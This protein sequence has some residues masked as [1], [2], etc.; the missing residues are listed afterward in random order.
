MLLCIIVPIIVVGVVGFFSISGFANTT[1]EQYA[2]SVGSAQGNAINQI[3]GQ[4]ERDIY[5]LACDG[6]TNA[7][8]INTLSSEGSTVDSTVM[9]FVAENFDNIIDRF[10]GDVL[11]FVIADIK[12]GAIGY[13]HKG[14][15]QKG[16][17]FF[18]FDDGMKNLSMNQIQL[19]KI[20]SKDDE[21][22]YGKDVFCIAKTIQSDITGSG[23]TKGILFAVVSTDRISNLLQNAKFDDGK[24]YLAVTDGEEKVLGYNGGGLQKIDSTDLKGTFTSTEK[25]S[26]NKPIDFR[27]SGK[28]GCFGRFTGISGSNWKWVC[29]YNAGEATSQILIP[30][31]ISIGAM[32]VLGVLCMLIGTKVINSIVSPMN[33]MINNMKEIKEGDRDTRFEINTRN[34]LHEMAVLFNG[35]LDEVCM[36]EELHKTISDISDNMLFEWDFAKEHMYVSDNFLERFDINPAECQLANGKFLDKVMAEEYSEQYKRDISTLLKNRTGHSGEY[37]M[38][39]KGGT[40]VWFTV[41][42]QCITDR[43]GEPLR[44]IGVVTDIDSEKKMELQLSERASYDFLSQLYNRSTFEKELQSEIERNAHAKVGV[45]FIDVDDFKFINDRFGHSV[46]DEVIKY[47]SGCIKQRVKGSGFA[48]RFGG[49]E[50]VLCITDPGQIQDIESLSLDLIDELYSGYRSELANVSINIKA[51]IGIAFSPEHGENG[52]QVVAAADEAMYFVKKN[53][54]ANYHIYQPEDSDMEGLQHTL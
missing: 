2:K 23:E 52:K 49:D 13:D 53:G 50:F 46:G 10:E 5:T 9:N 4:Y 11:N 19:S 47:V 30:V 51:S 31:L 29:V 8:A 26:E 1:V 7:V 16:E 22:K 43:L 25:S 27:A 40:V 32:L 45:L 33:I 41:R 6:K 38:L 54:K 35:L 48:G 24:G 17:I 44:V 14:V 34:E 12:T 42:A 39:T 36:S 28:V 15:Q 20:Y 21:H 37:Q 3:I 18:D